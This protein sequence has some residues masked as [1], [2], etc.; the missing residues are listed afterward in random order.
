MGIKEK[1][2]RELNK[3][4]LNISKIEE[5]LATLPKG[6]IVSVERNNNLYCYLK[7]RSGD[8]IESLYLGR[9]NEENV[10]NFSLQIEK[11]KALEGKLK[12]LKE[13]QRL[14]EKMLKVR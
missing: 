14:A 6:S 10:L 9:E 2:Q 11:R 3:I 1:V 12:K 4:N 8:T 5:E 13:E 7:R